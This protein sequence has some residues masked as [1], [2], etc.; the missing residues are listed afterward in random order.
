[1]HVFKRVFESE[2]R[3]TMSGFFLALTY[4]LSWHLMVCANL[5]VWLFATP[6][7]VAHQ[8]PLTTGFP[9]QEYWVC[10]YFLLQEIFPTQRLNPC[11]LHLLHWQTGYLLLSHQ[12]GWHLMVM[13]LFHA[14][15]DTSFTG[16]SVGH[17]VYT[18]HSRGNHRERILL[19]GLPS[20]DAWRLCLS[21]VPLQGALLLV[22]H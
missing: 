9:R 13:G 5:C 22:L 21:H 17:R 19:R 14:K 18:V 2:S 10:C 4:N 1:M 6:W 8:A 16:P 12:G 15:K 3:V 7:T 20:T 11:L